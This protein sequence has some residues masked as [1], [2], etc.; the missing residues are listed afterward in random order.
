M[1][2]QSGLT[3]IESAV[4]IVSGSWI[5]E[6]EELVEAERDQAEAALVPTK[7]AAEDAL[8]ETSNL[9]LGRGIQWDTAA[10][11][12]SIKVTISFVQAVT[13]EMTVFGKA[14]V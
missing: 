3:R 4:E 1:S 5:D 8:E 10:S 11:A 14:V 6:E 12:Y 2:K 13:F 7:S 9:G